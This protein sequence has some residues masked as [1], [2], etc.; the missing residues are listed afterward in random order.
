MNTNRKTAEMQDRK[1]VLS[2]LWIFLTVNYIYCDVFSHMEPADVKEL[3]T[4]TIGQF[5]SRKDSCWQ[6]HHDGD[7]VCDDCPVPGI[8]V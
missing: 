6:P 7:S 5:K 4:G 3:M 2:T 1:V 8:E